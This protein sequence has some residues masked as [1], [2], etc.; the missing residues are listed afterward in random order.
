MDIKK[1]KILADIINEKGLSSLELEE[2]ETRIKLER[3][4]K[5]ENFIAYNNVHED[6]RGEHKEN[7]IE[8]EIKDKLSKISNDGPDNLKN[9]NLKEIKSPMVGVYYSAPTPDSKPFIKVGDKVKKGDELCIIEAMKLMNEII[10]E[11][12]GEIVEICASNGDIVQFSQV[13]FKLK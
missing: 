11:M 3:N 5:H 1:I 10:S 7:E 2:G 13:L 6:D 4:I 9:D 12:D 8:N